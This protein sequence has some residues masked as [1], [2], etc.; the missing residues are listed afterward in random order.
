MDSLSGPLESITNNYAIDR[1]YK[2]GYLQTWNWSIQQ[3][4]KYNL[5]LEL[6]Y[7]GSKGTRLDIQRLP[8]RS[9]AGSPL[10]S[11]QR[12]QIGNAVGFTYDTSDGNSVYHALQVRF[13]RRFSRGLSANALYTF[14][15]SIDDA[16]TI[17]GGGAVVAQNDQN[18]SAERGLSSFDQRHVLNLNFIYSSP[19]GENGVIK[20][21]GWREKALKDWQLTGSISAA[22]GVPFTARVLGNLAN[23]GGT[24][25]VGSGRAQATGLPVTSDVRVV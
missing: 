19:F 23:I 4:L 5:V 25:A 10:T 9:A 6:G 21:S 13:T 7:Q 12:R 15:K 18:I 16:S 3:S 14:S 2:L 8:N 24:G 22:S 1:N 17:G 11:E 20:M